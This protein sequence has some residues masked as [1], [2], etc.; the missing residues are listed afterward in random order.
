M[1]A[2]GAGVM[3][4]I[5]L[6]K[7]EILQSELVLGRGGQG[8]RGVRDQSGRRSSEGILDLVGE[9]DGGDGPREEGGVLQDGLYGT[10]DRQGVLEGE[11]ANLRP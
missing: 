9:G 3:R 4:R 5:E 7:R 11:E 6:A 8:N 10:G 2:D 1:G